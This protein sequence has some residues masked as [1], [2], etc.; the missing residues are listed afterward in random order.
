VAAIAGGGNLVVIP[1]PVNPAIINVNDSIRLDHRG[2]LYTITAIAPDTPAAGSTTLTIVRPPH[3]PLPPTFT[4]SPSNPGMAFEIIRRPRRDSASR[5]ELPKGLYV[6]LRL[7][8]PLD[9]S[10]IDG[11][12]NTSTL[13]GLIGTSAP[14]NSVVV[15][16]D[17]SGGVDRIF[18]NG[19][20]ENAYSIHPFFRPLEPLYFFVASDPTGTRQVGDNLN[21][22]SNLWIRVGAKDG[23]IGTSAAAEL[24]VTDVDPIER[25]RKSRNVARTSQT[26]NQ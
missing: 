21:N 24:I 18:T 9:L 23:S 1:S 12:A 5:M 4:A 6:D 8:G 11:D 3:N 19:L 22:T 10:N 13:L 14:S 16:F 7:S 26:A 15:L 17:Q 25:I 2:P 20:V